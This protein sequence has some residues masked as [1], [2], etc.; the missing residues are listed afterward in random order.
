MSTK[1]AHYCDQCSKGIPDNQK[2]TKFSEGGKVIHSTEYINAAIKFAEAER[3]YRKAI[4]TL[5][6]TREPQNKK[7]AAYL[8]FRWI[9]EEEEQQ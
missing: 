6:P 8:E 3:S 5:A 2:A 9:A 1:E 4:I 7:E